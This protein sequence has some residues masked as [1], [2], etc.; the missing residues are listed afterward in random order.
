VTGATPFYGKRA[1]VVE[2]GAFLKR[3]TL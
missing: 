1:H 2:R 3:L